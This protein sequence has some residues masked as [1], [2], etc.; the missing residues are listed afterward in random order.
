MYRSP[1]QDRPTTESHRI[2]GVRTAV[3]PAIKERL[4]VSAGGLAWFI[5]IAVALSLTR[6]VNRESLWVSEVPL[7]LILTFLIAAWLLPLN[8]T[9][10][11]AALAIVISGQIDLH[12]TSTWSGFLI[13]WTC[14]LLL[15]GSLL[16]GVRYVR[17]RL[18]QAERLASTDDLT[19]LPNRRALLERIADEFVQPPSRGTL[20][21]VAILDCDRFKQ[22]NDRRGHLAGD[23]LL[24][25]MGTVFRNHLPE[26]N[27]VGRFGG[28]EFVL[29][30]PGAGQDQ[31][32]Q[33]I[34]SLRIAL[35]QELHETGTDLTF[36][37]GVLIVNVPDTNVPDT[38]GPTTATCVAHPLDCLHL[39]DGAMYAAKREAPGHTHFCQ[40]IRC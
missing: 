3:F 31:A 32:A 37:T 6:T 20:F 21:C 14:R 17:R 8:Q 9:S 26:N 18:E 36:S 12:A 24:I 30:L 35:S 19:G 40:A 4:M 13:R 15:I 29:L 22:V 2:S 11:V 34:E 7:L 23:Q 27:F 38:K 10:W 33:V 39:A 25:A 28:D 1:A 5:A 16:W